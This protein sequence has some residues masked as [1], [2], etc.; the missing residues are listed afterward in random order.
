MVASVLINFYCQSSR[1]LLMNVWLARNTCIG[2]GSL[3]AAYNIPMTFILVLT[4]EFSQMN[5][6]LYIKSLLSEHT[7]LVTRSI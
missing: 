1:L 2:R 3:V 4:P 7:S 6:F 5:V